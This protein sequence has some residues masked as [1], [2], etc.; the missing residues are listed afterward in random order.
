VGRGRKTRD[1]AG[2]FTLP[3]NDISIKTS[4]PPIESKAN[5]SPYRK[6]GEHHASQP[7]P[8]AVNMFRW[9]RQL[10]SSNPESDE[11]RQ[12]KRKE[13]RINRENSRRARATERQLFKAS[14]TSQSGG[15]KQLKNSFWIG[16]PITFKETNDPRPPA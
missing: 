5:P 6:A 9:L 4:P 16:S 14:Q 11:E 8:L 13:K 12:Q 10:F 7:S 3:R 15:Q 2:H 1:P